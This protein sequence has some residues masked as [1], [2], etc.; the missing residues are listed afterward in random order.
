MPL[1]FHGFYLS[2]C[3]YSLTFPAFMSRS[4]FETC[5]QVRGSLKIGVWVSISVSRTNNGLETVSKCISMLASLCHCQCTASYPMF[6][7]RRLCG[8]MS[9]WNCIKGQ[10]THS[11]S[12][13][14]L[15][16]SWA[17]VRTLLMFCSTK[18]H[19]MAIITE[20]I[21]VIV[22]CSPRATLQLTL[23]MSNPSDVLFNTKWKKWHK[24]MLTGWSVA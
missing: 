24:E 9:F 6:W 13:S 21:C 20:F 19:L 18:W 4:R 1:Y 11:W 8:L 22:F 23:Y 5:V 10:H 15:T 2:Y 16:S 12:V 3:Q 14:H 7:W 17:H